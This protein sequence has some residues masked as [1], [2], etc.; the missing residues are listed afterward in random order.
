MKIMSI[1]NSIHLNEI[2]KD[3]SISDEHRL[4]L[5]CVKAHKIKVTVSRILILIVFIGLWQIAADLKWIDPFLTSS[6][7]RVIKSC[8]SL[9]EDGTLFKHIEIT[10]YET[11][12]GF[13]LGTILGVIIAVILWWYPTVSKILDPY[14][15]VLNALPKVA[16]AP[17]I[18]FWIGNGMPAIIVIALLISIVTTIISVLSGFNE[19]DNEKIMLMK[20]FKASKLQI[21]RYLIFPYSIPVFISALKINVGLSW[22]GVIMGEFLVAK[23]GLGFLIVYGGQVAQLDTVM[24]SIVI[25]SVI[26]FLMYEIVAI[27]Q[28]KLVGDRE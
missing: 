5:K 23:S 17:I 7:S 21:L 22:V 6:P 19:I 16:L 8:I 1:K 28:K 11:I 2:N 25:L 13:S 12:L 9:Y 24:M 26:A 4:Y 3:N 20:T 14:L 10:C 18:I 15:V 27:L